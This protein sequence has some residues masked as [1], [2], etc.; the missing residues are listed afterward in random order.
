MDIDNFDGLV[1][2]QVLT[3]LG[4]IDIHTTGIEIIVINPNGLQGKIALQ[5]FIGM[6]TKQSQQ[7]RFLGSQ[8]GLLFTDGKNLLLGIESKTANLAY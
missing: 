7:F 5:N 3:E 4:D 8:L 6:C 1:F 2:F